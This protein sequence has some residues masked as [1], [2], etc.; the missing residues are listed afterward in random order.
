MKLN[1]DGASRGN[2]GR[3]G[4][5][6]II[7]NDVGE[8]VH[9]ISGLVGVATNNVVE[10]SM[11]EVGLRWCA[12]NGV[13]KLIIE[14]DSQVILNGVIKFIFQNWQLQSWIPRINLLLNSLGDY[15]IQ[16]MFREGNKAADYLENMGIEDDFAREFGRDDMMPI[17]LKEIISLDLFSIPKSGIG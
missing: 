4:L 1:F 14:G 11:L 3:S 8:V 10:I 2:P 6:A 9:A 15:H 13:V 12:S 5:G 7:R 16:H 17:G